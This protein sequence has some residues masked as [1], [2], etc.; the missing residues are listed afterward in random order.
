MKMTQPAFSFQNALRT[1][2]HAVREVATWVDAIGMGQYR[3]K[4]IHHGVDGPLLLQVRLGLLHTCA[5][6]DL[7]TFLGTPAAA[8]CLFNMYPELCGFKSSPALHSSVCTPQAVYVFLQALAGLLAWSDCRWHACLLER[9]HAM[10]ARV[11]MSHCRLQTRSCPEMCACYL[12]GTA[13]ESPCVVPA[14]IGC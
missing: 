1:L 10:T 8:A 11:L 3:H 2:I 9:T 4:L 6:R 7:R 14:R 13:S 12:W 5:G